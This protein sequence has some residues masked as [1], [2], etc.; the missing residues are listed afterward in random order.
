[1]L[2]WLVVQRFFDRKVFRTDDG[3]THP[4]T[5]QDKHGRG[6]GKKVEKHEDDYFG[7]ADKHGKGHEWDYD[8]YG[9]DDW[10]PKVRAGLIG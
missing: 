9:S 7:W 6:H 3:I 5:K 4:L 1:V 2:I 8:S 10:E